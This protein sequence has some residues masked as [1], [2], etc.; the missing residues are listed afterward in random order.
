MCEELRIFRLLHVGK[1]AQVLRFF[2]LRGM[3]GEIMK[4]QANTAPF[5]TRF[6]VILVLEFGNGLTVAVEWGP[7]KGG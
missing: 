3:L 7:T 5:L 4:N 2:G 1:L 6:L